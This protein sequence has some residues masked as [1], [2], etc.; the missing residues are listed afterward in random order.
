LILKK[1]FGRYRGGSSP[2]PG[3]RGLALTGRLLCLVFSFEVA[4][5]GFLSVPDMVR[6]CTIRWTPTSGVFDTA[7]LDSERW[8]S[9]KEG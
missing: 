2:G 5:L 3:T 1:G 8:F 9:Y 6:V 7:D 4:G